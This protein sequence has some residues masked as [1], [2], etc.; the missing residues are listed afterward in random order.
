[1]AR[2]IVRALR[3]YDSSRRNGLM[4]IL[5]SRLEVTN[6][7]VVDSG[8]PLDVLLDPRDVILD[9]GSVVLD[10]P[11]DAVDILTILP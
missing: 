2:S 5:S 11:L 7:I 10:V 8:C 6:R 9:T 4:K 3:S 1:M